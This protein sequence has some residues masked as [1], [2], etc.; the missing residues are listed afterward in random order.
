MNGENM[1]DDAFKMTVIL[2]RE[3]C[4]PVS[5]ILKEKCNIENIM[6]EEVKGKK[7]CDRCSGS[8]NELFRHYK[9]CENCSGTGMVSK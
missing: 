8:G 4:L 7:I 6:I 1:N 5:L 2:S 9:K 3:K